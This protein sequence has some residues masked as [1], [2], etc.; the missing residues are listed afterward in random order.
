M[1]SQNK[2]TI[3]SALELVYT[4]DLANVCIGL[5]QLEVCADLSVIEPIVAIASITTNRA[6]KKEVLEFLSNVIDPKLPPLFLPFIQ[7]EKYA[8]IRQE[9]L[10]VVWNSKLDYSSFLADFVE[11][12]IE[13]N[14]IIALECLT[15]LENLEG[16]FEEHQLLE[17]QL[18]LKEY[19][20]SDRSMEDDQK[21]TVISDIALYI[22]EQNEGVDADLL[23]D[24]EE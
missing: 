20:A 10:S 4:D 19:I 18:H 17:S 13:G 9:L 21:T 2:L 12:A 3:K 23:F 7:E 15:V 11:V 16:P 8:S 5:K 14:F 1:S 22:R 24:E 6:V